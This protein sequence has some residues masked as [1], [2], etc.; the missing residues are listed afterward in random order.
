MDIKNETKTKIINEPDKVLLN[1]EI[2]NK[3]F[4]KDFIDKKTDY[5][6]S[7]IPIVCDRENIYSIASKIADKMDAK[8][9]VSLSIN[10]D[11]N[12]GNNHNIYI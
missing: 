5:K 11:K 8:E 1:T 4:D 10:E 7:I 9:V 3:F 12:S 2:Y 6:R